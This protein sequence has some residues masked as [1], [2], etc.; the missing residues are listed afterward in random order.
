MR[1]IAITTV[2]AVWKKLLSV[3]AQAANCI[4]LWKYEEQKGKNSHSVC[5]YKNRNTKL[6]TI[7]HSYGK[8]SMFIAIHIDIIV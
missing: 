8:Y 1:E 2:I 5:A 3:A 6:V 7:L 4:V